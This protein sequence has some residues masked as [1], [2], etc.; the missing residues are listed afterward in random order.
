MYFDRAEAEHIVQIIST[1]AGS[2]RIKNS[3]KHAS[4][5]ASKHASKRSKRL[6]GGKTTRSRKLSPAETL[7][8][9]LADVLQPLSE[10]GGFRREIAAVRNSM[11]E[12]SASVRKS[13]RQFRLELLVLKDELK[14]VAAA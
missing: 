9:S 1:M 4:K 12:E 14:A 7:A 6:D 5:R 13:I 11:A 3:S 2:R 8:T 10:L